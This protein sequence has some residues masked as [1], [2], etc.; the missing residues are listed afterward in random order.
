MI[1]R[2]YTGTFHKLSP[3]HLERYIQEIAPDVA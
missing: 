3:K 2:S 1:K